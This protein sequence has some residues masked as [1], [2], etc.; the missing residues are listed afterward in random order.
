[1]IDS[2]GVCCVE[3]TLFCFSNISHHHHYRCCYWPTSPKLSKE[4][5]NIFNFHILHLLHL[6]SSIGFKRCCHSYCLIVCSFALTRKSSATSSLVHIRPEWC[7]LPLWER[8]RSPLPNQTKSID[9]WKK[10]SPHKWGFFRAAWGVERTR[11]RCRKRRERGPHLSP[12]AT[13]PGVK[14]AT[15]PSVREIFCHFEV[16]QFLTP[17]LSM[18]EDWSMLFW[19][20]KAEKGG[21]TPA[22]HEF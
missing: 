11:S 12:P 17:S 20:L 9:R 3:T 2:V 22:L 19:C 4:L 14:T 18:R 7:C 10:L 13:R 21:F 8:K 5:L 16:S 15:R 6:M 1:M